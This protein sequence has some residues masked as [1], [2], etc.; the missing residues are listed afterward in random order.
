MGYNV[1][2]Y[3]K[4]KKIRS[5][6]FKADESKMVDYVSASA[7]AQYIEAPIYANNYHPI[8]QSGF[9]CQDYYFAPGLQFQVDLSIA[10]RFACSWIFFKG[11]FQ[12][13]NPPQADQVIIRAGR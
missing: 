1:L 7:A 5:C 2:R 3:R 10:H 13:D 8:N 12:L 6:F 4:D 11:R 9:C